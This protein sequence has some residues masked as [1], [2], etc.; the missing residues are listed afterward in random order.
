[1]GA[2][3]SAEQQRGQVRLHLGRLAV[4]RDGP[5]EERPRRSGAMLG[6]DHDDHDLAGLVDGP[7]HVAPPAGDADEGDLS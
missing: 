3:A 1:M 2:V 4:R 7:V 5:R 6:R